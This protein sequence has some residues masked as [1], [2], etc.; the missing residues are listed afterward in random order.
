[1][2]LSLYIVL[3]FFLQPT[4][5]NTNV[6]LITVDGVRWQ[7]IFYGSDQT[8]RR[9]PY[10]AARDLAPNFYHYFVDNG[11]V[12]GKTSDI[13]AS[14]PVYISLPGYLEIMR[15]HPTN[16]C[17]SN[18]CDILAT[19]TITD[20]I[21]ETEGN[22]IGIF[23]SWDVIRK[24][25]G[26]HR[27]EITTSTG[28]FYRSK[29]TDPDNRSYINPFWEDGSY[30][31]DFYT[32]EVS[33]EYLKKYNPKFLWISLGDT[34]DWAHRGNYEM[35]LHAITSADSFVGKL[36]EYTGKS[37]TVYIIT[38]DHGRGRDWKSHYKDILSRRVWV[39]I[40]GD[41]VPARGFVSSKNEVS[42]S[43]IFPTVI[44]VMYNIHLENSLLHQWQE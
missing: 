31:P 34:D 4:Y 43:N 32:Q 18:I 23:S 24:V 15:G 11:I 41:S 44:D 7:E 8:K 12:Y 5:H 35:Y 28:K 3:L 17:Y 9:L 42:L 1:M 10:I 22:N 21:F 19:N 13:V 29:I 25:S 16:D 27:E 14:G 33:F 26:K 38:T 39:M 6:I 40:Y 20:F 36:I 37:N 30:R 2:F